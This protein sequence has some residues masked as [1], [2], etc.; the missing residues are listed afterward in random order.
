MEITLKVQ[1]VGFANELALCFEEKQN[2]TR[3]QGLQP[4]KWSVG[5]T[6]KVGW[7]EAAGVGLGREDQEFSFEHFKFEMSIRNVE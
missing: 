4:E 1:P 7:G 5:V 2:R 3:F 6:I